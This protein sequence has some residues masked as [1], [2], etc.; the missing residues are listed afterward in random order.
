MIRRKF[1]SEKM[2]MVSL[3]S[4]SIP[5]IP[6]RVVDIRFYFGINLVSDIARTSF[7]VY[8]IIQDKPMVNIIDRI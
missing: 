5:P 6:P 1:N 4:I 3:N 7:H 2:N 8:G